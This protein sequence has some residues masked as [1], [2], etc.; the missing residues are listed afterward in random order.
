MDPA[1]DIQRA[2]ELVAGAGRLVAMTGAGVS[3]DSGI[4]DFR[5]PNGV[6]TRNPGAEKLSNIRDYVASK[7]VREQSWQARVGHPG[8]H[9]KPN[10]AHEALVELER[11]GRLSAIITQN[12]DGLHQKAGS[13]PERVIELHGTMFETVCL[14]CAERRD[15]RE[16]LDRVRAGE[17]DPPCLACGGI[18]KSATISFGQALDTEVLDRAKTEAMSCDVLLA[19][20]TSL[21]VHPAAGLVGLAASAGA[22]VIVCNAS[23]TPYDSAASAVLRGPL[24]DVLPALTRS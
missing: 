15:M 13:D 8:W 4:P 19:A 7:D 9:A 2:R 11:D 10:R 18:L 21:T 14:S 23:E 3:T 17:S 12:I 16:A 5:G 22:S 20:G 6:W 24:G 1:E